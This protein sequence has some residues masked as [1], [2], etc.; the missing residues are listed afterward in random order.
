MSKRQK[1][2]FGSH[3]Q[4]AHV[5]AQQTQASGKASR[6]FF[7]NT[8]DIYSYG[9][10]YLAA[11]IHTVKGK[12]VAL[13]RSD[14]YSTS[15]AKHLSEI[16]SALHGL[17]PYFCAEDV[18][19]PRKAVKQLDREAR[20]RIGL[21]LKRIKIETPA[22]IKSEMQRIHEEFKVANKLRKL[23]GMAEKQP[24]R[25]DLDKVE[26]HLKFRLKRFKELNTPEQVE[27]RAKQRAAREA[28]KQAAL[29]TQLAETIR[30]FRKGNLSRSYQLG[31]LPY[32]ILRVDNNDLVTSR[33]AVV[34]LREAKIVYCRLA[35]GK[36]IRGLKVGEFTCLGVSTLPNGD[37]AIKI[38]CHNV[39][40]SEAKAVL[41]E[42]QPGDVLTD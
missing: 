19:D 26:K 39:L 33:G 17:M 35:N 37:K 16:R 21:A 15:T 2:V 34:P 36:D 9:Y 42:C 23:L 28:A 11:R 3:S 6:M 8:R 31:Q 5:W 27:R 25:S 12:Q 13:V 29:E 20:E 24:K 22:D 4:L 18:T 32:D 40:L 38:G 14:A 30:E 1:L 41:G 7:E 10:H